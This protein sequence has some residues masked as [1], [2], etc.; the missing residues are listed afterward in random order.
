MEH[1]YT[2]RMS[3]VMRKS[4]KSFLTCIFFSIVMLGASGAWGQTNYYVATDGDN[5][6]DGLTSENAWLTIQHAI[7]NSSGAD[8]VI[9]IAKGVY[10]DGPITINKELTLV[11]PNQGKSG[12]DSTRGD[13]ARIKNSK[14][15]VT[16]AATID[17]VEIYQTD[18]TADAVLIQAAATVK[19]SVINREGV[20]TGTIARGITTA[21][22]T[23]GYTVQNNLFTGDPSGGFFGSHKTWNSGLWINGGSGN[24]KDNVFENC[25]TAINADDF[26]ANITITGNTFQTSG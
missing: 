23:A 20:S 4:L 19:N 2:A 11:G 5:T 16:A 13:E 25:R 26:N 7:T 17:G 15:T 1:F 22:G 24:V 12:D 10:D 6:N 21:V 18:D 3:S 8:I 9:H 14:I